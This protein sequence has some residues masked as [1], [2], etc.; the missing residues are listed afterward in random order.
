MGWGC[1]VLSAAPCSGTLPHPQK[2]S[3]PIPSWRAEESALD[4][5]VHAAGP[6]GSHGNV[7]WV[8]NCSRAELT[9]S[10]PVP[11]QGAV[12]GSRSSLLCQLHASALRHC[13]QEVGV[14]RAEELS[15]CCLVSLGISL[16]ALGSPW[17]P[18]LSTRPQMPAGI[19][20]RGILGFY[21]RHRVYPEGLPSGRAREGLP[22]S[23]APRPGH[24]SRVQREHS[25]CSQGSRTER[26]RCSSAWVCEWL[27]V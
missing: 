17:V 18:Q 8:W 26:G 6:A 10:N 23:T 1:L 22:A 21:H 2:A 12:Q 15:S 9:W 3:R 4:P 16:W 14:S 11:R 5:E 25:G 19:L 7:G 27:S 13:P 20:A 24:H